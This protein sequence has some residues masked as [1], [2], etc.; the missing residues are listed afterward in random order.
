M[1]FDSLELPPWCGDIRVNHAGFSSWAVYGADSETVKGKPFTFQLFGD[2]IE[3]IHP[4]EDRYATR[5]FF[6]ALA[7]LPS[8]GRRRAVLFVHN[9]EFDLIS[10]F[11]DRHTELLE[12]EF[13]FKYNGWTIEGIYANVKFAT[14]HKGH[15]TIKLIDTYAYFQTSLAKLANLFCPDL[16]K[17]QMPPRLGEYR[18]SIHN[19]QF[20]AY[21]MR[22]AEITYHVGQRITQFHN[23]YDVRLCVSAPHLAARIFRHHF[24]KRDIPLPSKKILYAA[25]HSYH[26]GKNNVTKPAGIYRKIRSLDIISAYPAAMRRLPS[27]SVKKAYKKCEGATAGALPEFGVY[28][29]TGT[30][31]DCPWPI[32]YNHAFKPV[33]GEIR[34]IWVTGAELNEALISG[35]FKMKRYYGF[36]YDVSMD[37]YPSPFQAYVD[38]FFTGKDTATD[39]IM[40]T[41][42]KIM[43]NAL[44][45]KFIQAKKESIELT[46]VNVDDQSNGTEKRI[47]AGGLFHSFIATI[48]TGT[49][50][51]WIHQIEHKYKAIHT[52][53][54]GIFTT[55]DLKRPIPGIGGLKKECEG[56]LILFR[57]K[58]YLIYGKK[59][60]GIPSIIYKNKSIIKYATHGF[61]GRPRDLEKIWKTGN[62]VYGYVKVN[63]LR[64]S[65]R[66][67]L[68]VNAFE[69]RKAKLNY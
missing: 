5:D 11:Y 57:N 40:K 42:F 7:R 66:R 49:V 25:L 3:V 34:D 68:Q 54:D 31:R 16:P 19:R 36:Y 24:L 53:T 69:S 32:F 27:F 59:H 14:L 21:A 64:E 1:L 60:A 65:N 62:N 33:S 61:H 50:R 67:G 48:I 13:Y 29:V 8:S 41:F 44:Y 45:G 22:D 39:P 17:L 18:Y 46:S 37:K 15:R 20:S 30:V 51:A 35:E 12:E 9:L 47:V 26:G 55:R 43:L 23:Q 28:K 38:E 2:G 58:C 6:R 10:F 56:D 63:K 4:V 52:A